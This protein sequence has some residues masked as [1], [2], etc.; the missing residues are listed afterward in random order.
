SG[1]TLKA[2]TLRGVPPRA[3]DVLRL[4]GATVQAEGLPALEATFATPLGD[5]VL[6]SAA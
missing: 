2:L 1:V 5:V 3:R 6:Q 4:R